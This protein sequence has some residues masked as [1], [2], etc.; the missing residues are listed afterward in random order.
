MTLIVLALLATLSMG[1]SRM[2]R[3]SVADVG[4]RQEMLNTELA[5]KSAAQ[6]VLYELLTG[7]P[8]VRSV[9]AGHHELP[10][11]AQPFRWDGI[12]ISVQDEAGLMGM[13]LFDVHVFER[14]LG[15]WLPAKQARILAARV[16]DWVDADS[17]ARPGSF[18][19]A[20]YLKMTPP[21]IP[22]DAPLR[23]LDGLLEIPGMTP[24]I[25]N[26][27]NGKPGLRDLVMVGGEDVFNPATAPA[28]LIGA[29]MDFSGA[30][31]KQWLALREKHAWAAMQALDS[32]RASLDI[33]YHPGYAFIMHFR[34]GQ[35]KARAEYRLSP[36]QTVPYRLLMWQ[37]PDHDRG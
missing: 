16:A 6:K 13:A 10:V 1:L 32:H 31:E 14:L 28:V 22:R 2:A 33:A 27:V 26:G 34:M 21:M 5:M 29:V 24:Q 17:F 4:Q 11:D 3:H 20:A 9:M 36:S 37:Y 15:Q 18:E 7:T 35:V 25:Y 23:T 12:D 30:R 8:K 19:S